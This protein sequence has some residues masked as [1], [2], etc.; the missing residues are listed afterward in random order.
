VAN[1]EKD[2]AQPMVFIIGLGVSIPDHITVE[3]YR[4][5][6]ACSRLFSIVQGPPSLWLPKGTTENLQVVNVLPM[7]KE[8][9]LRTDNYEKVART[10]IESVSEIKPVG[11]VTYGNPLAYDSVAQNVIRYAQQSGIPFRVTPGISSIDTLLCDLRV[12]MAPGLQVYEASWL[13][14]AQVDLRT[15]VAAILLQLGAFGSFLAHYRTPPSAA[16]LA[17][18]VSYLTRFYLPSH[19]VFVVRSSNQPDRSGNVRALELGK[20]CDARTQDILNASLYI[21]AMRNSNL[22]DE[23]VSKMAQV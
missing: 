5:M 17:G 9:V 22:N 2:R 13:V 11:Y 3:A 12:D 16:S 1:D 8:G 14:A 10:I 7:Y 15:D 21:P 23:I 20:L 18:L 4:A 19:Q 6:T